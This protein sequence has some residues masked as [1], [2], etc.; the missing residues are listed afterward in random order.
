[1][2]TTERDC[3]VQ[4]LTD[5]EIGQIEEIARWKISHPNVIGEVFHTV[6]LPLARCIERVIP[7]RTARNAIDAAYRAADV[8]TD[9]DD[10]KRCAGVA[11]FSELQQHP[12]EECDRLARR[13][14]TGALVLGT[15]EGMLTGAGG[16][17]TT[18]LDVPLLLGLALRTIIKTGHCYGYVLNRPSDKTY[19]LG[20]LAASLSSSRHRRWHLLGRLR[21][22]ED[23]LLQE[24]QES[25][26][27]EEA[28]SL[29]FQIETFDAIPG[30]GAISGGVLN[31]ALLRRV[32]TTARRVFQERWLRDNGKVAMVE[33]R[34]EISRDA[35]TS[36]WREVA[37]RAVYAG[38]YY[39]SFGAAF[40]KALV[41]SMLGPRTAA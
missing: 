26:I 9:R 21:D 12:L 13:V 35:T 14:R 11:D 3:Q 34:P 5:Y 40:P 38:C 10:L 32:E 6:T 41:I 36:H 8:A 30:L 2:L 16:V 1:M 18:L 29:L 39:A 15:V 37:G 24:T 19:L 7:D 27:V 4:P 20:V 22:V 31:Y 25:L 33:P 28:A 17:F 23:L